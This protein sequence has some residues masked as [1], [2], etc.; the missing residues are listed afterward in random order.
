MNAETLC[1]LSISGRH[2]ILH[3]EFQTIKICEKW[4]ALVC[5]KLQMVFSVHCPPSTHEK[6]HLTKIGKLSLVE[7]MKATPSL[8]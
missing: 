8:V 2:H 1:F 6:L 5:P 7:L 4:L 3:E